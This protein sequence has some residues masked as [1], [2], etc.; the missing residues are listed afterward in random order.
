[1]STSKGNAVSLS[2]LK[3]GFPHLALVLCGLLALGVFGVTATASPDV[4]R[5]NTDYP[6]GLALTRFQNAAG[7]SGFTGAALRFAARHDAVALDDMRK[8]REQAEQALVDLAASDA[9]S[10]SVRDLRAATAVLDSILDQAEKSLRAP[11]TG[12]TLAETQPLL[13]LYPVLQDT[14]DAI[15]RTENVRG[16][17]NAATGLLAFLAIAGVVLA[18]ALALLMLAWQRSALRPLRHL[19]QSLGQLAKGDLKAPVWGVQRQDAFGDL[20]RAVDMARYQFGQLPD[21]SLISDQGPVRLKFEGGTSSLFEALTKNLSDSMTQVSGYARELGESAKINREGITQFS[22]EMQRVV[23]RILALSVEHNDGLKMLNHTL[24][25]STETVQRAQSEAIDRLT[26]ILPEIE[27]RSR[28]MGDIVRILGREA[29]ASLETIQ[30]SSGKF[31]E[32]AHQGR[33]ISRKF[34]QDATDLHERLSAATELLR[35]SGKVLAETNDAARS[36]LA[37]TIDT[38]G[39]TSAM[40]QNVLK[41]TTTRMGATAEAAEIAAK[42]AARAAASAS[43]M[44]N[45]IGNLATCHE[46]LDAQVTLGEQKIEAAVA[47]MD[48]AQK[49]F[50]RSA[51][52]M[53]DRGAE[54]ERL[55]DD[56]RHNNTQMLAGLASQDKMSREAVDHVMA[57]GRAIMARLETHLAQQAEAVCDEMTRMADR[58]GSAVGRVYE[59]AGQLDG[60]TALVVNS[61]ETLTH[62]IDAMRDNVASVGNRV[63]AFTG[64]MLEQ[65]VTL[66]DMGGTKINEMQRGFNEFLQRFA[67]LGQLTGVLGAIADQLSQILPGLGHLATPHDTKETASAVPALPSRQFDELRLG[68]DQSGEAVAALRRDLLTAISDLPHKLGKGTAQDDEDQTAQLAERIETTR[69]DILATLKRQNL[70]LDEKL[71]RLEYATTQNEA[72]PVPPMT[73]DQTSEALGTI[74]VLLDQISSHIKTLDRK[75]DLAG[76]S[77]HH[78]A[79][80]QNGKALDAVSSI[81]ASLRERSDE[82]IDRLN[83]VASE[84]Q[85]VTRRAKAS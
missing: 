38:L 73:S 5:L 65:T 18:G 39:K 59:T 63:I 14:V 20:A 30:E 9:G 52:T 66:S 78:G 46:R 31:G 2:G 71:T 58:A 53:A 80:E 12:F 48:N 22:A 11:E 27:E 26:Q 15:A 70:I 85:D 34:A 21:L 55:L 57:Q 3:H 33:E 82:V 64:D 81:F 36:R 76:N 54:F 13:A 40:L 37:A 19:T 75:I 69:S 51:E 41:E 35:S 23:K 16:D 25:S 77:E 49:F 62:A 67:T 47:N 24:R 7:P 8:A 84:L 72:A 28:S 56:L 42:G 6:A 61:G 45:T 50:A 10:A 60:V 83:N 17:G 29:S 4:A 43:V 1:M 32:A 74:A 68:I 79:S 44:E